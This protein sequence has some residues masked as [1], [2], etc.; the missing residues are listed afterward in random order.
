[1]KVIEIFNSIEGEGKRAGKITT[2]IRLEGCNCRCFYCDTKYSYENSIFV[3]MTISEILNEVKKFGANFITITG[4][5]PLIHENINDLILKLTS[6]DYKINIETNGTID[7]KNFINYDNILI[8][9]DYKCPSSGMEKRMNLNNLKILRESDVLKF[10]VQNSKDL[11]KM[12]KILIEN[13]LKCDIYIS[14]V[15]GKIDYKE[16]VEFMKVNQKKFNMEKLTFQLQL[17][18]IIWGENEKGV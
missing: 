8:T 10:V 3:E 12:E 5:E 6:L 9:M 4:G 18:K 15:F 13:D 11:K 1:M 7:I 14:P 2:F 17:H 16:I